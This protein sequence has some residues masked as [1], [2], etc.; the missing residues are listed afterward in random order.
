[1]LRAGRGCGSVESGGLERFDQ[2][3]E[4]VGNHRVEGA[5]RVPEAEHLEELGGREGMRLFVHTDTFKELNIGFVLDEGI[6]SEDN[7]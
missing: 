5:G 1:M 6:A 7:C 4:G 2:T 3:R